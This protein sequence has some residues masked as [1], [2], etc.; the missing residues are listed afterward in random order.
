MGMDFGRG[1]RKGARE[2]AKV[3]MERGK[4]VAKQFDSKRDKMKA[5]TRGVAKG[6]ARGMYSEMKQTKVGKWLEA[7]S[8]SYEFE[9]FI[10]ACIDDHGSRVE[11]VRLGEAE[12]VRS[13]VMDAIE[14]VW[15]SVATLQCGLKLTNE[16]VLR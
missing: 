13:E 4:Q 14:E 5:I 11:L 1:V 10:K 15:K 2:G 6:M 12:V 9:E 16:S 7:E 3:G 8:R